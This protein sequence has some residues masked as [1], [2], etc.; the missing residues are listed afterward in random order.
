MLSK[1]VPTADGFE[2]FGEEHNWTHICGLWELPYAKALIL[3]HNIDFMHQERNLGE[4]IIST[5]MDM[6]DRTKDN[7]K[8][9]RDLA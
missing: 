8:A 5:F 3:M 4:S 2:G 9:R 7:L 6:M 1:L